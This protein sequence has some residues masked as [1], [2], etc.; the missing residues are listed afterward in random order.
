[1]STGWVLPAYQLASIVDSKI[2]E[3]APYLR[4]YVSLVSSNW[5]FVSSIGAFLGS[6]LSSHAFPH[7]GLSNDAL[8]MQNSASYLDFIGGFFLLLG[9]RIGGGCTSGHGLSGMGMCSSSSVVSVVFMFAGGMATRALVQLY[10]D[11][12]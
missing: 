5:Q 4:K 2:E 8:N 6:F 10:P 3:N 7:T 1:M 12:I 11:S 9:A